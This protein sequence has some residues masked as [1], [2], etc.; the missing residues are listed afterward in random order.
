MNVD[1]ESYTIEE[2]TQAL[3]GNLTKQEQ[4]MIALKKHI[5]EQ[6]TA[7]RSQE[8]DT[9]DT[10]TAETSSI[11]SALQLLQNE[12]NSHIQA[13]N[14]LLDMDKSSTSIDTIIEKLKETEFDEE[15]VSTLNQLFERIPLN[16]Q[17]I[18]ES[19]KELAYSLQYALHLGHQMIEAIQG[20]VSYPPI[21]IYTAEGSKKLSASKRMM[22]NKVG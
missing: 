8:R 21:L 5:D 9:L 17:A 2:L 1:Q 12:K 3:I 14:T 13:F 20:A 11:V 18:R 19:S 6:L 15:L 7:V 4:N 22:V 10:L 16:A